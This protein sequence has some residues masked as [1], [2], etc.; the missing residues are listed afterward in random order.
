MTT[1]YEKHELDIMPD[2]TGPEWAAFVADIRERGQVRPIILYE[3]Q[4]LDGWQRHRACVE[5]GIEPVVEVFEGD[6]E[7]AF[8]YSLALNLRRSQYSPDQMAMV[9]AEIELLLEAR[10]P[11]QQSLFEV[12]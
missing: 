8:H 11:K 2:M 1:T 12:S 10:R 3:G 4:I 6:D 5:L 7:A 9:T